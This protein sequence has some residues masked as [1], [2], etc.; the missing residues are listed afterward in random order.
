MVGRE[1]EARLTKTL[2]PLIQ[3]SDLL[4]VAQ[5]FKP[6]SNCI[7]KAASHR[8]YG[9]SPS[10]KACPFP[11]EVLL[12]NHAESL[13]AACSQIFTLPQGNEHSCS[14]GSG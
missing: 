9:L 14:Q 5:R 10:C 13:P 8:K 2:L 7:V 12:G 11:Q 6:A 3:A 1:K 4:H